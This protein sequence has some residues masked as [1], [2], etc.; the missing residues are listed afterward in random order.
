MTMAI[1]IIRVMFGIASGI[2]WRFAAE[3]IWEHQ[4]GLAFAAIMGAIAAFFLGIAVPET[5]LD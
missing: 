1:R 3:F 4:P 2:G 5:F